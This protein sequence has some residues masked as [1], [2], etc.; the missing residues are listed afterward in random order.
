MRP[1]GLGIALLVVASLGGYGMTAD[2]PYSRMGV[3]QIPIQLAVKDG[4]GDLSP[5]FFAHPLLLSYLLFVWDGLAFLIGRVLGMIPS[6]SGFERL[7]FTNPALF[8]L[9]GRSVILVAALASVLWFYRIGA[10]LFT[11]RAAFIAA[12]LTAV[13]PEMIEWAHDALPTML[14]VCLFMGAFYYIVRILEDG[15]WR[16]AV[17]VRQEFPGKATP[18]GSWPWG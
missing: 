12:L 7:S 13:A 18:G 10:R 9:I 3:K 8:Y 1:W 14:M 4:T 16:D 17:S 6:V 2:L 11:H 5:H 15:R